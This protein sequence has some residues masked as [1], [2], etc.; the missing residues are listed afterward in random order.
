ML[1]GSCLCGGVR[2]EIDGKVSP[3]GQCHCSLCRKVSGTTGNAALLTA[4]RSF[5]WV[6]GQELAQVYARPSGF[7]SVFCRIC[8]SPMPVHQESGKLV[9]IPAGLLDDDPVVRVEQHIFVA[10]KAGWDEIS[11]SGQQYSEA[12][13]PYEP[14]SARER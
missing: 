10:S 2:F 12:A 4:S 5:R 1:R 13:P 14:R 6:A 3:V 8:G 7:R 9:G 11:G